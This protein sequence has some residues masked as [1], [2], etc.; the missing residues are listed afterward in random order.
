MYSDLLF[1][2]TITNFLDNFL[3]IL[4]D[5]FERSHKELRLFLSTDLRTKSILFLLNCCTKCW[6][7]WTVYKVFPL[8]VLA[9]SSFTGLE[10]CLV[11]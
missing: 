6:K 2:W 4:T 7:S 3:W 9:C 1:M 8:G 10:V 11:H 5:C